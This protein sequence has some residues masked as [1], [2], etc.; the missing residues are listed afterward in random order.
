MERMFVALNGKSPTRFSVVRYGNV[1]WST[2]SVLCLW[3][4]MVDAGHIIQTTGPEMHRYFFTVD[5]AVALVR[6]ALDDPE[7]V[8]GKVLAAEMKAAQIRA[9]LDTWTHLSGVKYERVAGRPGERDEEYLIGEQE[10]PFTRTLE[11][12]GIRHYLISF[13]QRV[14]EPAA[15]PISSR[16]AARLSQDEMAE[17]ISNPPLEEL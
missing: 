13:N 7:L 2:G 3:K 17:L 8:A 11:L 15:G 1:A 14:A 4:K 12:E 16:N 6:R 5:E 10:L 9:L